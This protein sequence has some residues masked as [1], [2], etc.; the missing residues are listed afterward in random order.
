METVSVSAQSFRY[1]DTEDGLTSRR[2]IAIEKDKT[3]FMW[4]LTQEGVDRYNGKQYTHYQLSDGNNIIQQFPN[5]SYLQVDSLGGIWITGKNGYIFK[6]NPN[7]DKYDLK[8]NFADTLQTTRRLPL[9]YTMLD[10]NN[11]IWLCTKNAQ[12]I[13]H[14]QNETITPLESPI[15]EEV[16]SIA[17]GKKNQYFIGTNR[18]IYQARLDGN[19]LTIEQAPQLQNFHIVQYIYYHPPTQSLLIGTMADGFY[20]YNTTL[21]TLHS[22]GNLKDVTINQVV[23]AYSSENEVLIATDGNGVY[24][25]NMYTRTLTPYL[26]ESHRTP[27]QLNGGIIKDI[28]PDEEGRSWLAVFPISV[29]IYSDKYPRYEWI[30][31]KQDNPNTLVDDQITYLLEDSD[32]DI[33]VATGNGISMFNTRTQQ[34][35]N[36]LSNRHQEKNA[37]NHVFISLCESTPGTILV[38]GYM[39]GMYRIDKRDMIPHYFTPQSEG[40]NDIRPDK[41]I[42]SIYRDKEGNI[43][44]GGYYN[45]KRIVPSTGAIEHYRTDYP[46]TFITEKNKH[47]LWIGTINGL[48]KFNKK[49]QKIQQVNLSSNPGSI[50]SIYQANEAITY[51]GTH[52]NG[53]WVYNNQSG[54]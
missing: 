52:G 15:K 14:I 19:R 6:Y 40:Y 3:G 54:K 10:N 12:Y 2:V 29:T 34:W 49:Q 18:N 26:F 36:M 48:Y 39:S 21:H 24:K 47:E 27:N 11:Q 30:R 5:L 35:R 8:L 33:W 38:G 23:P 37:E 44:A 50:N 9:T 13:Y 45:L 51:I 1:L 20:H 31:H 32:G 46:I 41:Y 43:W 4:F 17:Q 53:R 42:R 16:T 28:Y 7:L 22:I 25:M